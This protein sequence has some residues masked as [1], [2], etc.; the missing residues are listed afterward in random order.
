MFTETKP[1][2]DKKDLQQVVDYLRE[3]NISLV[4]ELTSLK[5]PSV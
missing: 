5:T 3:K 1:V 4:E 2:H